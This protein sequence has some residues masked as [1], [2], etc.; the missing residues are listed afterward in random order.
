[1]TSTGNACGTIEKHSC[2]LNGETY[3]FEVHSA[4]SV[5]DRPGHAVLLIGV[6]RRHGSGQ[7]LAATVRA[8]VP[9]GELD[10][11]P[12]LLTRLLQDQLVPMIAPVGRV[13]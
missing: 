1:M 3:V 12:A 5:V 8:T 13:H 6:F 11:L 2:Y 9:L 10:H 7:S 4:F